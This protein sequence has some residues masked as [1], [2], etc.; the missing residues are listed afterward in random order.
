MHRPTDPDAASR[1]GVEPPL[2]D[3]DFRD[4]ADFR[5]AIRLFLRY[6]EERAR[7]AGITPQQHILLLAVRGHGS[8][9]NI[10]IGDVAERLQV[11]HHSASRL[12]ERCVQ[13]GLLDRQADPAD[14][15]KALVSLTAEGQRILNDITQANWRELRSLESALFRDSLRLALH[16]Y[17][18]AQQG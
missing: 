15:R 18:A 6:A 11:R 5:Y 3:R 13:R 1:D 14:R 16:A 10:T 7:A 12:V 4:L 8:Y 9:P 17:N 2:R